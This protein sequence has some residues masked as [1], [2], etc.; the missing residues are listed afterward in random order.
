V[1]KLEHAFRRIV[2]LRWWIVVVYAA[3]L[4]PALLLAV[5]TPSDA[6]VERLVVE[7]DPDLAATRAFQRIFPEAQHAF[8]LA[9]ADQPFAP[10][11][12]KALA[13]LEEAL[14]AVPRVTPISALSIFRGV[15]PGF[16]ATPAQ[17]EDLRRFAEG[18]EL[19]RRQGFV[20]EHFH[21]IAL[22]IAARGAAERDAA[23]AG[24]DAAITRVRA[25]HPEIRAV[26]RVGAPYLESWLERETRSSTARY[27]PLFGLFVVGIALF[28]YRSVRAL[29]AI[30][31]ALG[32][33]VALGIAA[34][35]LLGYAFTIVSA[36]VPLTVMV[37][38]VATL[39]YLHSRFVDQHPGTELEAHHAHALANKFVPVTASVAAAAIG[40]AALAVSHIRPIRELGVWTAVAL[41]LSW[42]TA[43]TLFPAL[44]RILRTPTGLVRPVRSRL[45]D[46]MAAALP[47]F[48]W[49]W[50]W[51]LVIGA[52]AVSVAGLVALLGVPGR[53]APMRVDVDALAYVDPELPAAKDLRFFEEHVSGLAAASVW[54]ETPAGAVTDPAVLR[55]VDRFQSALEAAP[56]VASVIGPTTF[57]RF[58]R[59]VA[60]QGETLPD[61][62]AAFAR[63]AADLEQLIL[64]EPALR[65][66]VDASLA[67]AQL[68]VV[69][70]KGQRDAFGALARRVHAEWERASADP[71]LRG[72]RLRIVGESLL[73][74]KIGAHLVPTLLESFALTA[75]LIFVAFLLVFRSAAARL[76]AMIPSL[77][78][79]LGTFLAMRL[80]GAGLDV[81]TIL[82]ATTVLGTTENDQIHFFHHFQER[83]AE[84][85]EGA[86][87]HTLRVSGRAIVFATLINGMGFLALALSGLPPMRHFGLV[88]AGAFLL[89]AVAD[90][91]ALPAALW[92]VTRT[93]PGGRAMDEG[94]RRDAA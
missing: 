62:P 12:V 87:R 74:A 56:E 46:R 19:F 60:G 17:A 11:T 32:A 84:D 23:L 86:L 40:F 41:A 45:Y 63:M 20:G 8:L 38:T 39:V 4:P 71:A 66:F 29:G 34:G 24:V 31:V 89:S 76:M 72:V 33:S 58:R 59:F 50:R 91:T 36:L 42:V 81:A 28:L 49:R 83:G 9:E 30:L 44:Q 69:A 57:L 70:R 73:Q 6:A 26:R 92:I 79:I 88:T 7:G 80:L 93:R 85:V 61:D 16:A 82:V 21:G 54:L 25:A 55:A 51:P 3:L 78:A 2:R 37:T 5:R 94:E 10:A 48:T 27:F 1:T 68:T 15:R 35:A 52:L 43:F 53:F 65:G 47:A 64:L 13:A 67:N 77:F 22:T 90:F 18:T 75:G 14:G